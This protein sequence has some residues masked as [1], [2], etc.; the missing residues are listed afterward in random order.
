VIKPRRRYSIGTSILQRTCA[1]CDGNIGTYER[2]VTERFAEKPKYYHGGCAPEHWETTFIV[3]RP[4]E[5][6]V[7]AVS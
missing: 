3:Y 4:V 2:R 5:V 6:V 7:I 1:G